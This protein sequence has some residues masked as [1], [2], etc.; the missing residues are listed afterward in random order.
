MPITATSESFGPAKLV[1]L[2]DSDTGVSVKISNYGA[3]IVS[4]IV[5][6]RNK[7][8]G[9]IVLGYD[10]HEGYENGKF[11][12]G[13]VCGRVANRIANGKFTLGKNTYNLSINRPPHHLHGGEKGFNTKLWEPI[14]IDSKGAVCFGLT[15]PDGE[16]GYPGTLAID[17]TYI[18]G[19]PT[20]ESSTSAF[21]ALNSLTI[22]YHASS[23]DDATPINLTNHTYWNLS[24][25]KS[26]TIL[27]HKLYV[28]ANSMTA[29]D[30]KL[31]PTGEFETLA[32]TPFDFN[33]SP[34]GI[35]IGERIESTPFGYDHNYVLNEF[36]ASKNNQE[37][38]T[39][40][41]TARLS[42]PESGRALEIKTTSPGVQVYSG[43]FLNNVAG[44]AGKTYNKHAG[45]CLETQHFPDSV[46]HSNFPSTIVQAS[47]SWD[48]KTIFTFGNLSVDK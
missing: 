1:T 8:S 31:I 25:G 48:N 27:N 22:I 17:V 34:L 13:A 42:D 41:L 9:D 2:S 16:E 39:P 21:N 44:K 29:V 32:G 14:K 5:P 35:A 37:S 11:F 28:N 18:L 33:K 6:D 15:S 36:D 45:I 24:G 43:N 10:T 3:T 47:E 20:G 7:N 26:D 4:I 38:A 46:N 12:L 40:K 19:K 23:L 30:D